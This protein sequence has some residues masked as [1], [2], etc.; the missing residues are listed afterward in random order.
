MGQITSSEATHLARYHL[1]TAAVMQ[2]LVGEVRELPSLHP[3]E[4]NYPVVLN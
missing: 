1:D 4:T 2:Y 3:G